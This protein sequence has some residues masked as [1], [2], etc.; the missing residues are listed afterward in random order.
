MYAIT[1]ITAKS[2]AS[3]HTICS[4]LVSAFALSCVTQAKAKT[5][6]RLVAKSRSP[7]WRT[8]WR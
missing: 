6:L 4:P 2:A 3:S 7:I 5:E 8:A 1:G